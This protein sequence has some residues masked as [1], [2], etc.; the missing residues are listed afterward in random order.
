MIRVFEPK[1]NFKEKNDQYNF[2]N[3]LNEIWQSEKLKQ[4]SIV[5]D[6]YKIP[7]FGGWFVYLGYEM[8]KEIEQT[9]DLPNS[10]FSL[11]DAFAARVN[12]AIIFDNVNRRLFLVSDKTN[13]YQKDFDEI[14]EDIS[15]IESKYSKQMLTILTQINMI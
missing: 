15:K 6:K 11:P 5:H 4:A 7:F 14:L 13:D 3:K 1:L 12:T 9:L 8:A 10:P 2:F